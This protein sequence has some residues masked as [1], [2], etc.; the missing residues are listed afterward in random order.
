MNFEHTWWF[1]SIVGVLALAGTWWL[2]SLVGLWPF[3]HRTVAAVA[4]FGLCL[5][6]TERLLHALLGTAV[7]AALPA[8]PAV[9][10][11]RE[12]AVVGVSIVRALQV[13]CCLLTTASSARV[14]HELPSSGVSARGAH[15]GR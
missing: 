11:P 10:R 7:L 15:A 3:G 13:R 14:N 9:N 5:A 6:G 8:R 4:V 1:R 2:S 12:R